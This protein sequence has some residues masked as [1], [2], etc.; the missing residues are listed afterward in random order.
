MERVPTQD[1][2]AGRA[3]ER[4]LHRPDG[5]EE[6]RS[7]RSSRRT[8]RWRSGS[9]GCS[10]SRRSCRRRRLGGL[11]RRS[12]GRPAQAVKGAAPD[13]LFAMT[14]R[15]GHARHRARAQAQGRRRDRLPAAGDRRLRR[16]LT[17]PRSC[18]APRAEDTGTAMESSDGRVRLPL[19]D[20]PR[21]GL[22][23]PRRRAQH[24]LDPA[25]GERLRR[26]PAGGGLPV[27]G[28]RPEDLLH[29]QLQARRLLPVH[30]G[31]GRQGSA[32]RRASCG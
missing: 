31:A 11:P 12:A 30:P 7:R 6:R 24:D 2:R 9:S 29:L 5:R 21:R 13:R 20:L 15:P 10:S 8:R 16:I 4:V 26:P 25:P 23:G 19:A 22:R 1:L 14:H 32:T 3:H 28:G 27:R 17:R 18:C